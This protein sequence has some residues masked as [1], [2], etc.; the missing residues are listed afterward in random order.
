[1]TRQKSKPYPFR[2]DAE[3]GERVCTFAELL[4]HVK[5]K[6]AAKAETIKLQAWQKFALVVLFGWLRKKD[7]RRRFREAY[8]RIPRKN[9]KSILAAVIGLYMLALDG[10]HGAEVYSG[11]TTEKQAWEVFSPARKILERTP[12]LIEALAA[13]LWAKSIVLPEDGSK[14]EPVIGK[15]G[16][17][18][19]P[20]CAI[21]DEYHEHDTPELYD[22]MI[23]GMGAREQPLALIIT[24]AGFNIAGPC[25][26]KDLEAQRMLDGAVENDEL[27]ALMYGID[28][29]DDWTKPE[30]LIKAN[31]NWGV[32][33]EPDFLL[34]QQRQAVLN[35]ANVTRFKTK[36]LNLW[37][38]AREALINMVRW[39][40]GTDPMLAES[41][42]AG[43]PCRICI[44]L[45]SKSDLC[46]VVRVYEKEVG[47]KK[48]YYL[49]ARYYLPDETMA[50]D[51]HNA[52][53]YQRWHQQGWLTVT[54]GATVD[55]DLVLA[56]I[57]ADVQ[58]IGP[59]EV[60]FDP[61]NATW[62]GQKVAAEGVTV[63]EFTQN[64]SNMGPATDEFLTAVH[65]Y[66][67]HH[68]G[69]PI[70]AWCVANLVAKR[71]TGK[72]PV[73]TKQKPHNKIDGAIAA[74]MGCGRAAMPGEEGPVVIGS[75]YEMTVV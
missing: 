7:G 53:A 27:F 5:G 58:R 13:E 2:F 63:V 43:L 36:H 65:D 47:G 17:G 68:D 52:A 67:M 18:S 20:S 61:A 51:S 48:H 57:I 19:S 75:D 54:D 24:T 21:I 15:P 8:L 73:P 34:A 70:T 69:N 42:L 1:M 66:R 44:D 28:D 46:A 71:N 25:Y 56:D 39:N 10:E 32:S 30:A 35:P 62:M 49:F 26:D 55:F 12:E 41:E 45:A 11:A 16:D 74:I 50:S 59:E 38:S 64:A 72:L 40:A 29:A 6:W 23:S 22:T 9:G 31:P 4:P 33:I 37:C 14:F 60:V 3:A